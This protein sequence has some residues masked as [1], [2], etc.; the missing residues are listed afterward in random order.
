MTFY[1]NPGVNADHLVV[2]NG[3][4]CKVNG[5]PIRHLS[6]IPPQSDNP[7]VWLGYIE[8]PSF[9]L[10]YRGK[11]KTSEWSETAWLTTFLGSASS[12]W[13]LLQSWMLPSSTKK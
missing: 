10:L 6:D 5:E 8:P 7:N 12:T 2:Q 1:A 11:G 3:R 4:L 13:D 9:P